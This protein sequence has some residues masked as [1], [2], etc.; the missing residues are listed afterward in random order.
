MKKLWI[1]FIAILSLSVTQLISQS[2]NVTQAENQDLY[3]LLAHNDLLKDVNA[4]F[5]EIWK[6]QVFDDEASDRSRMDIFLRKSMTTKGLSVEK[7]DLA[8][9]QGIFEDESLQKLYDNLTA[10]GSQSVV[11][12]LQATA[13]LEERLII[14]GKSAIEDRKSGCH[15]DL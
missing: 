2:A 9:L 8:D 6:N 10:T 7:T 1:L 4:T 12:A 5:T 11:H 13:E 3:F 14:F 15:F